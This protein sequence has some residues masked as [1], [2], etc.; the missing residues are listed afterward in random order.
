M[1]FKLDITIEPR[2]LDPVAAELLVRVRAAGLTETMQVRGRLTGPSCPYASTVEIAYPLKPLSRSA[3]AVACRVLIPEPSL[4]DPQSPFLYRG[5]VELWDG[6]RLVT[7]VQVQCGLRQ[8]HH[9]PHGLRLNGKLLT[10]NG[11]AVNSLDETSAQRLR[12][13]GHNLLVVPLRADTLTVWEEAERWGFLVLGRVEDSPT[14]EELK[15]FVQ[16][17]ASWL[18]WLAPEEDWRTSFGKNGNPVR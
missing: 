13:E 3:D 9:G 1:T 18:G 5:P 2:T 14:T 8:F 15:T 6:E 16:R 7:R 11:C 4:W 17:R 12:E 10:L